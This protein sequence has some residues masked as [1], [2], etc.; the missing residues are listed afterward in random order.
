MKKLALL[1][2][3]VSSTALAK[4][5]QSVV[6]DIQKIAADPALVAACVAENARA[7]TLDQIKALDKIWQDAQ[8]KKAPT[9]E[10]L[11]Y[12]TNAVAAALSVIEKSK[13]Y[14]IEFI[15]TD[16]QGANVAITQMT[17][18]YWQGDE[19]KFTNS[20]KEGKGGFFIAR[21]Q[22]DKSTGVVT[23]QVSVSVMKDG[24]AVGTLTVG[25]LLDRLP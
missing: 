2:I 19:P 5:A 20:F 22:K 10:M 6:P 9:P 4:D 13:P 16:N 21:P 11:G 25:V 24:K 18:D 3:L 14:F 12:T 15:L 8:A 7:K 17:S 1:L 23:S